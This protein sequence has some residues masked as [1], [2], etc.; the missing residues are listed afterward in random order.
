[1]DEKGIGK[2]KMDGPEEKYKF[3][4]FLSQNRF[5][6]S[7]HELKPAVVLAA[8][9]TSYRAVCHC[10]KINGRHVSFPAGKFDNS[11]LRK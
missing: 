1:M 5:Y 3:L 10:A 8:T 4:Q 7:G 2:K 6:K 11:Q 9:F